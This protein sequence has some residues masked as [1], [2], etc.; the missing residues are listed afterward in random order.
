MLLFFPYGNCVFPPPCQWI[1]SKDRGEWKR[2]GLNLFYWWK[3]I[4][5]I[6][7]A[8]DG[9]NWIFLL[10]LSAWLFRLLIGL[11]TGCLQGIFHCQSGLE[12]TAE[13]PN[14]PKLCLS[15]MK[16]HLKY[17]TGFLPHGFQGYPG[18]QLCFTLPKPLVSGYYPDARFAATEIRGGGGPMSLG[19]TKELASIWRFPKI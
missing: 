17:S 14:R 13:P 10:W 7:S 12:C 18:P 6:D 15:R 1:T 5:Y 19:V 3:T 11:I 4:V 8:C 16:I 9:K 2:N